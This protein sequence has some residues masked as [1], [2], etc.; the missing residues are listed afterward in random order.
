MYIQL[1]LTISQFAWKK[2]FIQFV[3]A[4]LSLKIYR[5][6]TVKIGLVHLFRI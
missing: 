6:L 5:D 2:S 3:I 4:P 1:L